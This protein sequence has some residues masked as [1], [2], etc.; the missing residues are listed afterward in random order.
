MRNLVLLL[1]AVSHINTQLAGGFNESD[2]CLNV[3]NVGLPVNLIGL[4]SEEI[5]KFFKDQTNKNLEIVHLSTQVVAG[6][7]YRVILK[8]VENGQTW[9]IGVVAFRSL[10]QVVSVTKYVKTNDVNDI[11]TLFRMTGYTEEK[12]KIVHCG[13]LFEAFLLG[14]NAP[15]VDHPAQKPSEIIEVIPDELVTA[16]SIPA[17]VEEKK[18]EHKPEKKDT[19]K[20]SKRDKSRSD[21]SSDWIKDDDFD[22]VKRYRSRKD[23]KSHK[24]YSKKH[25]HSNKHNHRTS[26]I[27]GSTGYDEWDYN[28]FDKAH[29]AK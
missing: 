6:L 7:N 20:N 5:Q 9:W 17:P 26:V 24:G 23:R 14:V 3:D 22:W 8:F 2:V 11:F 18:K 15:V 27:V 28:G 19:K 21:D 25:N 10:Q 12:L 1:I 4:Q 13:N 16:I 29:P